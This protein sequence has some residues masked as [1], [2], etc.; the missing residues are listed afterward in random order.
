MS[1]HTRDTLDALDLHSV[2]NR[3]RGSELITKR[4]KWAS[5]SLIKLHQE[6][7]IC[8]AGIDGKGRCIAQCEARADH[9]FYNVEA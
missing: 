6:C 8:G 2:V 4:G 9:R 3:F 5:G 7:P 1:Y